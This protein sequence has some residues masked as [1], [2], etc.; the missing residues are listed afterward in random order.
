MTQPTVGFGLANPTP[1]SASERARS[2]K[3]M[4]CS[5]TSLDHEVPFRFRVEGN[6]VVDLLAGANETN[7]QS[8]FARNGHYDAAFGSAVQFR[9]DDS[10]NANDAGE[11]PSLGEPILSGRRV[12]HEQHV[13][14]CTWNHL[15]RS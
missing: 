13:M 12:E 11:L 9:Q 14:W 15:G 6:Q 5:F 7:R 1:F 10:G 4:S 3:R 2:M 8:E